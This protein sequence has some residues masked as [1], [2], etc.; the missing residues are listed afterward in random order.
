ME[1]QERKSSHLRS[2]LDRAGQIIVAK[3]NDHRKLNKEKEKLQQAYK[4]VKPRMRQIGARLGR[5][6]V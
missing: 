3:D 2:P 5:G 4:R 6:G 1:A